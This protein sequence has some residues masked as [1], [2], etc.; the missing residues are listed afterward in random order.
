MISC[1]DKRLIH[2]RAVAAASLLS[3]LLVAVG[4][5]AAQTPAQSGAPVIKLGDACNRKTD[6][7]SGIVKRDACGR[8]YCGKADV[9]EI[10]ELRPDI[11]S[12]IKCSWKLQ[13]SEKGMLCLCAR[14]LA[15]KIPK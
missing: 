3:F 14:N 6:K 12:K 15:F 8:W 2:H 4:A 11:A 10:A 13:I 9:K 1:L 7:A 5:A